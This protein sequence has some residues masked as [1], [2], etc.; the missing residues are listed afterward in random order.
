MN[1]FLLIIAC[2]ILWSVTD[3]LYKACTV[4]LEPI[5]QK[6]FLLRSFA[7]NKP[8]YAS[9]ARNLLKHLHS[10]FQ[11]VKIQHVAVVHR[12]SH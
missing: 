1:W 2:I 9:V 6:E 8:N 11:I 10:L 4:C 3:V 7:I 5:Y 12:V